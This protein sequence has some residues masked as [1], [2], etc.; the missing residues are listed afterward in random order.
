MQN[1]AANK[2]AV[3]LSKA[4]D[5][6]SSKI[7][8]VQAYVK[9]MQDH[10]NLIATHS[11]DMQSHYAE[12]QSFAESAGAF[13]QNIRDVHDKLQ[14]EIAR[15]EA[16]VKGEPGAP[17]TEGKPGK[18][19]YTPKRGVDY[20]T[21]RDVQDIVDKVTRLIRK[22]ENGKDAIVTPE[23]IVEAIKNAPKDI[24]KVEHIQNLDQTM[25]SYSQVLGSNKP[26]VHGG[27]DTIAAGTGVTITRNSNGDKVITATGSS[28]TIVR[29]EILTGSGTAFTLAHTPIANTLQLFRGGA[30]QQATVDYTIVGAAI[31]L[32]DTLD[33]AEV[34]L[35]DYSY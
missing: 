31:T 17:G 19:A 26:Y 30:R 13:A 9:T 2:L 1:T 5:D 23:M 32:I 18:D 14:S 4:Y 25:R 34:L 22:P 11:F 16:Y 3:E 33:A 12:M 35:A 15:V 6:L 28:G 20:H 8:D 10:K 7:G 21:P 29:D 27:G 24:L